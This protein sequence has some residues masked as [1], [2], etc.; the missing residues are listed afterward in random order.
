MIVHPQGSCF[1]DVHVVFFVACWLTYPQLQNNSKT[2]M[3]DP[4][5]ITDEEPIRR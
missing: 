2:V 5:A 4:R 3:R 1:G